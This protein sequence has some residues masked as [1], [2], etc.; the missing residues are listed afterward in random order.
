MYLYI[1]KRIDHLAGGLTSGPCHHA[2]DT[3]PYTTFCHHASDR[4]LTT[5]VIDTSQSCAT[6]QVTQKPIATAQVTKGRIQPP[7]R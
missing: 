1:Y 7:R 6:T 2:G 5:Q 3:E 4:V